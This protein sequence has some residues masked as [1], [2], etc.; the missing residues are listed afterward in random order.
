MK[1]LV[2]PM[3]GI[4]ATPPKSARADRLEGLLAATSDGSELSAAW[5]HQCVWTVARVAFCLAGCALILMDVQ[6]GGVLG[7][8]SNGKFVSFMD[9]VN[10]LSDYRN[11][12]PFA[13]PAPGDAVQCCTTGEPPYS[14][15]SRYSLTGQ[16]SLGKRLYILLAA[17]GS[18]YGSS[19]VASLL[20][21]QTPVIM[22]GPR[23]VL[24]FLV[25][26]RRR[27]CLIHT[28]YT[29]LCSRRP[30]VA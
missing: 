8:T 9:S 2:A 1:W 19:T 6:V 15:R 17:F 27:V 29:Q 12:L 5:L 13:P 14:P 22:K 28:C 11:Q 3:A 21:Q 18:K 16:H 24:S 30:A 25:R 7:G 4:T 20:L 10:S 23:H 26:R